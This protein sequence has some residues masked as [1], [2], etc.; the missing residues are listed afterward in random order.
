MKE[1]QSAR[2]FRVF[3]V[4]ELVDIFEVSVKGVEILCADESVMSL[5]LEHQEYSPARSASLP[6]ST[7]W[8]VA[9]MSLFR[10]L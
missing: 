10:P 1:S 4:V 9:L 5:D 3:L 6:S 7:V 2:R 8:A